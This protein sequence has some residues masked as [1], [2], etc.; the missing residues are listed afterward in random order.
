MRNDAHLAVVAE[1]AYGQAVGRSDV[2][3]IIGDL[4]VGAG[5]MV[6]GRL[7][8]GRTGFAGQIGHVQLDPTG[9]QC[10]CGRRGCWETMVGFDAVL[11]GAASGDDP[12]RDPSSDI[13]ARVESIALRAAAGD[14][15]TLD[16]L[17]AVGMGLGVGG[18][19]L[20][21]LFNPEVIVLGGYFA[22]LAN[23]LVE[24]M[25]TEMAARVVAPGLGGCE[26]V[27][28]SLG[29]TAAAR[30]GAYLALQSVFANPTRVAFS[31]EVSQ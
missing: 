8:Q 1:Q 6:A 24:P 2:V 5:V 23:Y 10:R 7:V 13:E 26:V 3:S 4:S 19:L 12:V 27:S 25:R 11:R 18:A 31:T 29:F 22:V 21:N 15:Q 20:V 16:A 14:Q 17:L 9:R 28:S 30:G